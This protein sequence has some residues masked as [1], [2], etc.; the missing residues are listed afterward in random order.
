MKT[1]DTVIYDELLDLLADSADP[2][3]IRAFRLSQPR[4]SRLDDLLEKN[5]TGSLSGDE[6]AELDSFEHFEHVVRMLKAR[7]QQKLNR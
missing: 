1:Q 2:Q 5:R 3:Q 7:A 4:Q 6:K